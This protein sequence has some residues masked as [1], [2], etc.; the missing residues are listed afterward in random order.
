MK[1]ELAVGVFFVV[2]MM[3]LGYFTIVMTGGFFGPSDYYYLNVR[4]SNVEGLALNDKVRVNGVMAGKVD[5]V[6][7]DGEDGFVSVRLRML[8][9]FSLYENYKIKIRP[10]GALGGR[11]VGIYPGSRMAGGVRMAKLLDYSN[12][13]GEAYADAFALLSDFIE[14]NREDVRSTIQNIRDITDKINT[15]KG[16]LGKLVNEDRVHDSTGDLIKELREA[17]EDTR[18]QAPVTSFIRAA[19]TAF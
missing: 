14:E 11:Y 16:T 5:D 1:K 7:L 18:E 8:T 2:S 3:I 4:F 15:G 13:R 10:E 12:L 9:R 19:L 17:I 6:S